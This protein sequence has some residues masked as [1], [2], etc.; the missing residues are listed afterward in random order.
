MK[1]ILIF[2]L[3]LISLFLSSEP[4]LVKGDYN[5][6]PYEFINENGEADGFNVEIFRA[7][8]KVMQFEY[9]LELGK[10]SAV[11]SELENGEIDIITGM[12]ISAERD[13]LV[14][15]SEPHSYLFHTIF[16]RKKD[17]PISRVSELQ[18]KSVIVQKDDIMH[19]FA[20]EIGIKNITTTNSPEASL[21]LLA[22]GQHDCAL[23]IENQGLYILEQLNLNN[24]K[25][26]GE[27]F[28]PSK[29]CFAVKEGDQELL[30]EL[31]QGLQILHNNGEYTRIHNKWLSR[32]QPQ[33]WL[34]NTW[35]KYKYFISIFL[36]IIILAILIS[37]FS[38]NK[39]VKKRTS[40]LRAS[41]LRWKFALEG[42]KQGVWDWDIKND[43]VFYS[44]QWKQ[45]LGYQENEIENHYNEWAM[46]VH[47]EDLPK[48]KQDLE[49]HIEGKTPFYENLHRMKNKYG[50]Y[51]WVLA[52][53]MVVEH[54]KNGNATR[55]IG[56]QQDFS[57][58]KELTDK[59]K[60]ERQL[61]E[62]IS[63]LS[64]VGIIMFNKRG[65]VEFS[66]FTSLR[67]LGCTREELQ[68]QH[69]NSDMFDMR[70]FSDEKI[71]TH[72]LPFHLARQKRETISN[73]YMKMK[74]C[75]QEWIYV[76]I[77]ATPVFKENEFDGIIVTIQDISDRIA[78]ERKM[79]ANKKFVEDIIE[80]ANVMIIGLNTKGEVKLFNEIAEQITDYSKQEIMNKNYFETIVPK[81]KY[82][83]PWKVFQSFKVN[84][85]MKEFGENYILTKSGEEKLIYW[86]NNIIESPDL[87]KFVVTFGIDITEQRELQKELVDSEAKYR[88]LVERAKDGIAILQ[89]HKIIYANPAL[90]DMLDFKENEL[91]DV[92]FLKIIHPDKREI[93]DKRYQDRVSGKKVVPIYNSQ[94]ISKNKR[95]IEV[96]IN[97]G[98][99]EI[100]G[101][102][103]DL[104]MF[105]DL[106]NR[107]QQKK[108][109]QE[110]QRKLATLMDNLPGMAYRCKYDEDWTMQ[111][112]SKGVYQL[113]GY[114]DV[115]IL[116]NQKISYN[117]IIIPQDR[118]YVHKTVT[119]AVE[120]DRIFRLIYRIKTAAGQQK[121]IL[122]QGQGI[123][124]SNGKIATLEGLMLDITDRKKYE[125]ELDKLNRELEERV[126]QRTA[127]L[128]E[129]L[130]ELEVFSYSV[131]HDLRAPL[132]SI[133]GFTQALVEDYGDNFDETGQDYAKRVI[134]SV[135][136]M[137]A[138]I[139]DLLN[140]SRLSRKQISTTEIELDN[141]VNS[142]LNNLKHQIDENK[143]K[144]VVN[145]PLGVVKSNSTL[146]RQ[147]L[148]NLFTNALKFTASD[149]KPKIKVYT[150]KENNKIRLYI[151]DNGI[152]I[153][154]EYKEKI[155]NIFERLHGSEDYAGTGIGLALVKKA[156]KKLGG[157]CGVISNGTAGSTFWV[158]LLI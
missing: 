42:A 137:Q 94:L 148:T 117:E 85:S 98:L 152:G 153:K 7:V 20:K 147:I 4:L 154:E 73:Y 135:Q 54:D 113:T 36:L 65:Y 84:H 125:Q 10:W 69:F 61:L 2:S 120:A 56:T 102:T 114:H 59:L 136:Q 127:N 14:D 107:I 13:K 97:A 15:F 123:K 34:M 95:T 52:K 53:G 90:Y 31:N 144:I 23:T 40:E 128:K 72:Q 50:K 124:D 93:V 96:E 100:N 122:E 44:K 83:L 108:A 118:D 112:I 75:N 6:P 32:L 28:R 16:V 37:Y 110:S 131:S 66:N 119:E 82:P 27:A 11:R 67:I 25:P 79:L 156:A 103:A 133:E 104:V 151:K 74:T 81:D 126:Q 101:K 63:Q 26:S 24:I 33:N 105:R 134:D 57:E 138:L 89:E 48:T 111:F 149:T 145:S 1:K 68:E 130:N 21:R 87:G 76:T 35:T 60:T 62:K 9:K 8:A 5:Y 80:S 157:D 139:S 47:P 115:D 46:R 129:A 30:Q 19:D 70:N 146:L 140:Y 132:R 92:D 142:V 58:T 77:N 12:M 55:L 18:G 91:N 64:P 17:K 51:I 155:F 143:A 22:S 71:P 41:E 158:D 109:L 141:I 150:D 39:L 116:Q 121:W 29:Y 106:S 43:I 88:N 49:Q 3:V 78:N 86:R 38:L 45:M 99:I